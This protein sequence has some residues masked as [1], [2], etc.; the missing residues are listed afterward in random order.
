MKA[1][2]VTQQCRLLI[3]FIN[4]PPPLGLMNL[5]SRVYMTQAAWYHFSSPG[6]FWPFSCATQR[7]NCQ[8][9]VLGVAWK[10]VL[11]NPCSE[12][13]TPPNPDVFRGGQVWART[14]ADP[15]P[16]PGPVRLPSSQTLTPPSSQ[17]LREQ[18]ADVEVRGTRNFFGEAQKHATIRGLWVS[19]FLDFGL[20]GLQGILWAFSNGALRFS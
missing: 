5:L 7:T 1:S 9:G 15:T 17:E 14:V 20:Q 8:T 6:V 12:L 11:W 4:N 16:H 2:V 18:L 19:I 13:Q 3:L 10:P